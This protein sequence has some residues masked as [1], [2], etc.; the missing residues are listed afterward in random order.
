M[1]KLTV[2]EHDACAT[3]IHTHAT[4]AAAGNAIPVP[5]AG[6]AADTIAMTTMAMMLAS[7][8]GGSIPESVA[9]AMAVA[10]IKK[11]ALKQ[12]I[13]VITKELSKLV[14]FLGQVVAPVVSAAMLEAAGWC[15]VEELAMRRNVTAG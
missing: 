9:K 10:S 3:I 2:E 8:L 14:P 4:A 6:V 11:T 5:G 15:L 13:K 7:A 12:P 1:A